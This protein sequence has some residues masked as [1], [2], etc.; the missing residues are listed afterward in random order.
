M[1]DYYE[2]LQISRKADPETIRRVYR[3]LLGRFHPDNQETG[4]TEKFLQLKQAWE[5]LSDPQRRAEYDATYRDGI[6]QPAPLSTAVD[7]MDD[8]EGELNRRLALL[9]LLYIQRRMN[10]YKPEVSLV[11]VEKRMGFPR[12]YL[13]FTTWYLQNKKYIAKADNS[14]FTLTV[15][16]VDFVESNRA[17]IPVLDKLLT[18][19]AGA[20]T[21]DEVEDDG[22]SALATT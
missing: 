18:S 7:F 4:N 9:A 12:D 2:F 21:I 1:T 14:D 6:P 17:Q 3:F 19:G 5:V 10:P 22:V 8:L 20:S 13:E 11:A 16:G 15:Q